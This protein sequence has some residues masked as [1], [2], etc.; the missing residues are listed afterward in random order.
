VSTLTQA[1]VLNTDAWPR[2]FRGRK[3]VA[4]QRFLAHVEFYFEAQ[5]V[6]DAGRRLRDLAKAAERV[7]FDVTRGHVEEAP[8]DIEADERGCTGYGPSVD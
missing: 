6:E 4:L 2:R 5:K 1:A 8:P 3:E 7:G